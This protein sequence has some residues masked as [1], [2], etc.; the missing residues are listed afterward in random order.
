MNHNIFLLNIFFL[1]ETHLSFTLSLNTKVYVLSHIRN[2]IT[3]TF[4]WTW[5][6]HESI[7]TLNQC[8]KT[9]RKSKIVNRKSILSKIVCYIKCKRISHGYIKIFRLLDYK[10]LRKWIKLFTLH[11]VI[12]SFMFYPH[13]C[14]FNYKVW[15]WIGAIK[16]GYLQSTWFPN[17]SIYNQTTLCAILS[18]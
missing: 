11:L 13:I 17:S 18:I 15:A 9:S 16:L 7:L 3:S 10:L 5:R 8:L 14:F 2:H 12:P 6:L 4:L 1:K